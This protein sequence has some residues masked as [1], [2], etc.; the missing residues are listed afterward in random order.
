MTL[1]FTDANE[2]SKVTIRNAPGSIVNDTRF[3]ERTSGPTECATGIT[4]TATYQNEEITDR[5]GH[6]NSAGTEDVQHLVVPGKQAIFRT[7]LLISF[8]RF[9]GQICVCALNLKDAIL[10]F[11]FRVTSSTLGQSHKCPSAGDV[12]LKYMGK[13]IGISHNKAQ[14]SVN[15][16]HVEFRSQSEINYWHLSVPD[17]DLNVCITN[18]VKIIS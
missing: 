17:Y 7:N 11:F 9:T 6:T 3:P 8:L 14:P 15:R 10:P 16:V 18:G 2:D 13:C 5:T 12:N 1:F 4:E